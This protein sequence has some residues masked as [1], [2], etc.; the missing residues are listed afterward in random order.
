VTTLYM[1][2]CRKEFHIYIG[3]TDDYPHRMQKQKEGNGSQ[4]VKRYGFRRSYKIK[5]F[6]NREDAVKEESHLTFNLRKMS[7]FTVN[8]DGYTRD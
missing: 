4:F 5:E 2:V 7:R 3:I 1:I 8:G 6:L